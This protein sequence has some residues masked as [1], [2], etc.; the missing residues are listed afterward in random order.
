M[1]IK[2]Q[3][4]DIFMGWKFQNY[5]SAQ[6]IL[7]ITLYW[8]SFT[9][10]IFVNIALSKNLTILMFF[11]WEWGNKR[12]ENI[13]LC[14]EGTQALCGP[15]KRLS[16]QIPKPEL[17]DRRELVNHS[18]WKL[19]SKY[20]FF[21]SHGFGGSCEESGANI[22]PCVCTKSDTAEMGTNGDILWLLFFKMMGFFG[23]KRN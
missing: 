16:W 4:R 22:S 9:F 19:K 13:L 8:F 12:P 15:G 20:L 6:V 11:L 10:S 1:K 23:W 3:S 21:S 2:S 5:V 18:V 14:L 7:S 17:S